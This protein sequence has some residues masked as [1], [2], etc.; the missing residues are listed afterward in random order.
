MVHPT[1]KLSK[2]RN[3]DHFWIKDGTL[4][5]SYQTL[6]GLR[7]QEIMPIPMADNDRLT[8]DDLIII[9]QEFLLTQ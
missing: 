1:R 6:R 4:F 7:F 3:H 2:R 8:E 9:E 5:E